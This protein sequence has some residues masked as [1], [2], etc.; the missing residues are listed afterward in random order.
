MGGAPLP[1]RSAAR[2]AAA[3]VDLKP[4]AEKTHMQL[5][6]TPFASLCRH[7][8][9]EHIVKTGLRFQ[10]ESLLT[11]QESAEAHLIALLTKA[12]KIC[13][14]A[15]RETCTGADLSLAYELQSGCKVPAKT[16]RKSPRTPR[17]N[18]QRLFKQAGISRSAADLYHVAF[19][20]LHAYVLAVLESA[21]AVV[22]SRRTGT[23]KQVKRPTVS[24]SDIAFALQSTH[25][26]FFGISKAQR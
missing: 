5:Q 24:P 4:F 6:K 15:K 21:N 13:V 14:A 19:Q 17:A 3:P 11:L 18:L 16:D 2:P 23:V 20:I 7:I 9:E 10:A 1:I 8:V 25:V 22:Q 12:N 26:R